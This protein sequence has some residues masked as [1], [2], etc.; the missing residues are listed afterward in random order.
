[1]NCFS[2]K[3]VYVLAF[4]VCAATSLEARVASPLNVQKL[5]ILLSAAAAHARAAAP[6]IRPAVRKTLED[7]GNRELLEFVVQWAQEN[8]KQALGMGIGTYF[9]YKT[10]ADGFFSTSFGMVCGMVTG[11]SAPCHYRT[12]IEAKNAVLS[13]NVLEALGRQV[14]LA[15]EGAWFSGKGITNLSI[16]DLDNS[17][18]TTVAGLVGLKIAQ[19]K[20][21]KEHDLQKTSSSAFLSKLKSASAFKRYQ[22]T[23]T[24]T[25]RK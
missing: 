13:G 19:P 18:Y 14:A 12:F 11:F 23:C 25:K 1:M 21:D 6:K 10:S 3:K 4:V 9:G 7:P 22:P 24:D 20:K 17:T 5:D 2:F 8:P 15:R 16:S